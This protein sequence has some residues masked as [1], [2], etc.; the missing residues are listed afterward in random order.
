MS[1]AQ[2]HSPTRATAPNAA[3][4]AC[5]G[6]MLLAT[7][8]FARFSLP[9]EVTF[10]SIAL[11]CGVL[12][13]LLSRRAQI[14]AGALALYGA[15]LL[16]AYVSWFVNTHLAGSRQTSPS[17]LALLAA[18]YLPFVMH[19][20]AGAA[21]RA[22]WQWAVRAFGNIALVCACAGIAQFF[23]QFFYDP[24]WLFDFTQS[25]PES[26]RAS[27]VY[28]TVIKAG[29]VYKSNG[30]FFR[31]PSAFSYLVALAVV[32][33]LSTL[34]RWWRIAVCALALLLTYSGTGLL[35]LG[36]G[37]LFPLGWKSLARML[38]LAIVG[39]LLVVVLGEA[40]NLSFTLQRLQEFDSQHSSAYYRYVAPL[41]MIAGSLD[42]SAW[43]ALIGH[44]PGSIQRI[45]QAVQAFDPTWAKLLFEYGLLGFCTQLTLIAYALRRSA[46]PAAIGAVLFFSW[47][48][49]G[50]HLLS[51]DNVS[52]LYVLACL[53]RLDGASPA[54]ASAEPRAHPARAWHANGAAA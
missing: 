49:M 3:L 46:V 40:L 7:T 6:A 4:C 24:P 35:A 14:D 8:V 22:G 20:Q 5:I 41:Y 11:Y 51:P 1:A 34:R 54:T 31:E 38:T 19:A 23:A 18:L 53:W 29:D 36:L 32:V 27:G 44:G 39:L 52:M 48:V 15:M 10:S 37:L 45:S 12:V 21:G 26:L 43:S 2:G 47:L 16:V 28:N 30:F 50:G 9:H 25:I 13:L 17:S 33:E 42:T